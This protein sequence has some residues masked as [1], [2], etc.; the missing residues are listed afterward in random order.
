MTSEFQTLWSGHLKN[1]IYFLGPTCTGPDHSRKFKNPDIFA[2][3]MCVC[4]LEVTLYYMQMSN[5][6]DWIKTV[7]Q[8]KGFILISL[9]LTSW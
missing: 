6:I 1:T 3:P 8:N 5:T 2:G 7:N 9:K 4:I